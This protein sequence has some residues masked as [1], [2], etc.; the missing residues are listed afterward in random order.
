MNPTS[1]FETKDADSG[2][3]LLNEALL[4]RGEVVV[5]VP[6]PK[7]EK[8]KK[9]LKPRRDLT[10]EEK[11]I[12]PLLWEQVN[13]TPASFDKRFAREIQGVQQITEGQSAQVW[14]LFKRYR[15]QIKHPEKDKLLVMAE[16]WAAPELRG[17]S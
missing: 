14:R 15:R 7:E 11:T 13:Y 10:E 5:A 17:K 2:F 12:I 4:P 9:G 16:Q 6:E 3:A 1:T 8:P